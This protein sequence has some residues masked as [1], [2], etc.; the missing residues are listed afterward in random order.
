[1]GSGVAD[2][3]KPGRRL[4]R[5]DCPRCVEDKGQ[6]AGRA[7]EALTNIANT[8][9]GA[10]LGKLLIVASDH[11]A[12]VDTGPGAV[13]FKSATDAFQWRGNHVDFRLQECAQH[14]LAAPPAGR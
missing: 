5:P 8:A 11:T 1:M 9:L 4:Q 10:Q 12:V 7:R 6:P 3:G 2:D 14:V 13:S